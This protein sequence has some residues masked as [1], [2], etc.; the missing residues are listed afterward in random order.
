[1]FGLRYLFF[2][3]FL[4]L[5]KNIFLRIMLFEETLSSIL[6]LHINLLKLLLLSLGPDQLI[7]LMQRKLIDINLLGLYQHMQILPPM[8]ANINIILKHWPAAYFWHI[9]LCLSCISLACTCQQRVLVSW[10][11]FSVLPKVSS[12]Y[13]LH[14]LAVSQTAYFLSQSSKLQCRAVKT[15]LYLSKLPLLLLL[16]LFLIANC[17]QTVKVVKTTFYH[18]QI[19]CTE[20][21]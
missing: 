5:F 4:L 6:M 14:I 11:T 16:H 2:A 18:I 10:C 7:K 20:Q 15:Y 9:S 1:M 17:K 19:K 21:R 8:C 13:M 12:V 3:F